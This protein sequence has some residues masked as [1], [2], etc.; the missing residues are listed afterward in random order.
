MDHAA[1]TAG[2]LREEDYRAYLY[3]LA[4]ARLDP[5]LWSKLHPED[6]VQN[7][8]LE[9]HTNRD[10]FRG[11]SEAEQKMWLRQILLHNLA[12]GVR[13]LRRG[14]RDVAL[15]RSLEQAIDD[16]SSRLDAWLAAEQSSPSECAQRNEQ[17]LRVDEVLAALPEA[18]REVVVLRYYHG[19]SL[20]QIGL[21][22]KRSQTA[23]AGLLHRGM[24]QLRQVLQVPE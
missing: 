10:Q 1:H 9:A 23:V 6:V 13:D 14:K 22:L 8:L 3:S 16:S 20:S 11:R 7:T 15:E 21:H 4:C 2:P 18:Q 19:W 12:N 17:L 24:S 5:R